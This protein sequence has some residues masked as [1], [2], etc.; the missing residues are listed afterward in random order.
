MQLI[1]TC[2]LMASN[3]YTLILESIYSF[4]SHVI[5]LLVSVVFVKRLTEMLVLR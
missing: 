4:S 3:M 5:F 2:T 1:E